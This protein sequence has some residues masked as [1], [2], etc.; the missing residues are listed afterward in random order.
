YRGDGASA[1]RRMVTGWPAFRR[2]MLLR[3]QYARVTLL[4][5]RGRAAVA[6]ARAAAPSERGPLLAEAERAAARLATTSAAWA[7]PLADTIR[8]GVAVLRGDDATVIV[9]RAIA[10]YEVA[11]KR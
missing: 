4:D 7:V 6:A 5:L 2:S 1:L 11:D 8:A 9:R 10:G 3:V